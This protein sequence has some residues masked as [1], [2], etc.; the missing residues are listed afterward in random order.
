MY[1]LKIEQKHQDVLGTIRHWQNLKVAFDE[2]F[3]WIKDF[4]IEQF[5]S[6]EVQQIPFIVLYSVRDNLL[7]IK[8]SLLPQQKMPSALLWSPIVRAFPIELPGLNH[9]YFGIKEQVSVRLVRSEKE[10]K[11]FVLITSLENAKAYILNAPQVRL[12]AL[13]WVVVDANVV[14]FG[15]PLLPIKGATYWLKNDFLLPS[16]YDFEFPILTQTIQ[17]M[18][19]PDGESWVFW[20]KDSSY[21][22][23]LKTEVKP[24]S[25]SSFRLTFLQ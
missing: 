21:F 23:I 22:K 9:N 7:F 12:D 17:S 14:I 3:V 19:S 24:L 2:G 13:K 25:I 4:T 20:Q 6:S 18:V 15:S 16:G 5:E 1:V 10:E 8:E 11:G